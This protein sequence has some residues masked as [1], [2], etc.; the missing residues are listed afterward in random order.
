MTVMLGSDVCCKIARLV[1]PKERLGHRHSRRVDARSHQAS[2]R[3]GFV[4][5]HR[6]TNHVW[7]HSN[8]LFVNEVDDLTLLGGEN[9]AIVMVCRT[10]R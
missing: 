8:H 10:A 1:A 2:H 7:K 9:V 3:S 4:T 5:G 6:T